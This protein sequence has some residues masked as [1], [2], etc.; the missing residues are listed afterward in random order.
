METLFADRRIR[1]DR[2]VRRFELRKVLLKRAVIGAGVVARSCCSDW[3]DYVRVRIDNASCMRC[4]PRRPSSARRSAE[5][6]KRMGEVDERLAKIAELERKVRIIANLPGSPAAGGEEVT[7]VEADESEPGGQGGS[8]RAVPG[9]RAQRAARRAC[10][11]SPTTR[12]VPERVSLLDKSAASSAASPTGR[13]TASSELL[14]SLEGKHHAAGLVAV[15]LADPRLAHVALRLPHLAV[16]GPQ[17]VPRGHRHRRRARHRR[18]RARARPRRVRGP[19]GP[20]RQ[21]RD[22]RPRLRR[23]HALRPQQELS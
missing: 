8:R 7:A 23:A 16:H 9:R 21:Q 22:H 14:A 11:R 15:D 17:A 18:G 2:P 3:I 4:A 20:A 13:A 1:R 6:E 12:G 5:F 10:R 19:E